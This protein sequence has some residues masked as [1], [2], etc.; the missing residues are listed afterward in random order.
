MDVARDA[1]TVRLTARSW[2]VVD[3]TMDNVGW[4]ARFDEDAELDATALAVRQAGWDQ[5]AWVDGE[6][7]PMDQVLDIRLSAGL[8]NLVIAQLRRSLE[9]PVD[10]EALV[11]AALTELESRLP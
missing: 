6:W 4:A 7:P 5:V 11:R 9:R 3:A 8:W 2:S 1:L 10:D